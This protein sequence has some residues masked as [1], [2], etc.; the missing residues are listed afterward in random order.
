MPA[1]SNLMSDAKAGV[2]CLR[3][4]DGRSLDLPIGVNLTAADLPG[5]HSTP[6]GGPVARVTTHP[7]DPS[8]FGFQNLSNLTWKTKL[9]NGKSAV[10]EPGKNVRLLAGT[11]INFGLVTGEIRLAAARQQGTKL[12]LWAG[13]GVAAVLFFIIF[14]IAHR[15]GP[16]A[17]VTEANA[18]PTP[19]ASATPKVMTGT[20]I[21]KE[22]KPSVVTII[23]VKDARRKQISLGSGF[24][25][26]RNLVVTNFH[27]VEG[28]HGGGVK[29]V[30][31][32]SL[33]EAR[34]IGE[35]RINDLA[36]LQIDRP[37]AGPLKLGPDSFPDD[38]DDVYVIG[39]PEGF[40]A[41]FSHGNVSAVRRT[42]KGDRLQITA[43]I[44]HGNSGGPVLNSEG[45]VVG[46][47]VAM[48]SEGQ[49]INFAVPV[50]YIR[51]LLEISH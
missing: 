8:S 23:M 19:Q 28:T 10:V 40:E 51:E 49:N 26:A 2:F 35:D 46:V 17:H 43:P 48:W 21:A 44:S 4:S 12:W 20:Q 39:S 37:E 32:K 36:L 16:S 5:L 34:V 9:P 6:P 24:I 33:Y 42:D 29:F 47:S 38:G 14:A 18:V 25:V 30:G 13:I 22:C 11:R 31:E 15:S 27:V 45:Q 3:L 41:S 1:I 7:T 50:K